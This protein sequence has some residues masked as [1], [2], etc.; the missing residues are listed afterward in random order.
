MSSIEKVQYLVVWRVE[1]IQK[2]NRMRNTILFQYTYKP[3][4][5]YTSA[6]IMCSYQHGAHA[7]YHSKHYKLD[8]FSDATK[9]LHS[10]GLAGHGYLQ[11]LELKHLKIPSVRGKD[12]EV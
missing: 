6:C 10:I 4:K 1:G 8:T 5:Q 2:G 7:D 9:S 12:A 11:L 3:R